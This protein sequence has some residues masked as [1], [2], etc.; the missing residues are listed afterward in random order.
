MR[1]TSEIGNRTPNTSRGHYHRLIAELTWNTLRAD[2]AKISSG[3]LTS[4]HSA[5]FRFR[6]QADSNCFP[7]GIAFLHNS[8]ANYVQIS[9]L[10]VAN[11]YCR[12]ACQSHQNE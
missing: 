12:L 3:L 7:N 9:F 2:V 5:A 10:L 1:P 6:I 11:C 4:T 8:I